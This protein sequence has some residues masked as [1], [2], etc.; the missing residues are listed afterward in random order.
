[1]AKE[2]L[3]HLAASEVSYNVESAAGYL[4]R[5]PGIDGLS[6]TDDDKVLTGTT[7]RVFI[8]SATREADSV[9]ALADTS[10]VIVR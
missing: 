10:G 6:G 7:G 4:L 1:M 8:E 5:L 2:A 3:R 9:V